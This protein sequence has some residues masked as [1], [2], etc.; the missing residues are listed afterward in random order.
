MCMRKAFSLVEL[1]VVI[2]IIGI[3]VGVATP[4][5]RVYVIKS[6]VSTVIPLMQHYAQLSREYYE[7]NG[8]FGNVSDLGLP[9]GTEVYNL[10]N[11]GTINQYTSSQIINT[12]PALGNC[13]GEINFS[14]NPST[15]GTS[16]SFDLQMVIRNVD[17]QFITTCGIPWYEDADSYAD[18]LRYFPDG[19]ID[20]NVFAC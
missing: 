19:C 9:T 7:A 14:F 8:R 5:L 4:S 18:V 17:G 15:L 10:A 6:R 13:L 1:M 20:Q 3:L 16:Q 2:A 12:Y 11:P